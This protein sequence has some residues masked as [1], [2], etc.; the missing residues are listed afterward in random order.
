MPSPH[1]DKY[2]KTRFPLQKVPAQNVVP[3]EAP[4]RACSLLNCATS[5]EVRRQKQFLGHFPQAANFTLALPTSLAMA[6]KLPWIATRIVTQTFYTSQQSPCSPSQKGLFIDALGTLHFKPTSTTQQKGMTTQRRALYGPIPVKTETFR[7][8]RAPLAHTNFGGN[9]Y[10]PIIGPYLFLGKFVWTNG[11]ES[12]SKV[13]PYTGIGPWMALP[14][15]SRGKK[16][17]EWSGRRQVVSALFGPL[18]RRAS[19]YKQHS[20]EYS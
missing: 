4:K 16:H 10:G 5:T 7:E 8:H 11:P 14:S 13:S 3:R 15:Y 20:I 9:S 6:S 18:L 12:S 17:K 19:C 2:C 1:Q